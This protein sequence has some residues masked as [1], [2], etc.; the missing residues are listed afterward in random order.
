MYR[1]KFT[2]AECNVS[3]DEAWYFQDRF[4]IEADEFDKLLKIFTDF[5]YGKSMIDTKIIDDKYVLT[6]NFFENLEKDD[7]G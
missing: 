3:G 7:N 5:A 1:W 2:Y 4:R 6:D